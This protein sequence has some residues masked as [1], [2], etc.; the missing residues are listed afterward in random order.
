MAQKHEAS[1]PTD[2]T[3][4]K[5]REHVDSDLKHPVLEVKAK[6]TGISKYQGLFTDPSQVTT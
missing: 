1:H 3:T 5:E 2:V 6:D 4:L